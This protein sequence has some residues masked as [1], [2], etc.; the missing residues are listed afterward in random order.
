[1]LCK[2]REGNIEFCPNVGGMK[3]SEK[4]TPESWAL[5]DWH[6]EFLVLVNASK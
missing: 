3:L 1:M 6:I 5:L 2:H 4:A